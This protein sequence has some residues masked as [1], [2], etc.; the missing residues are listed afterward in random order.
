MRKLIFLAA[1]PFLFAGCGGG[2]SGENA[3]ELTGTEYAYVMPETIEGG[4]TTLDFENTGDEFHEFALAKIGGGKTFDDVRR[5]L[6]DPK[7]Q[8]QPPPAWV[9]I[10][11]GIPTLDAG[12]SAALTQN[13]EPGSYVLLCFL[14]A[15]DGKSH[16]AHGMVRAFEVEGDAGT[17]APETDA[18]LRLGGGLEAPS[19]EAG[20]RTLELKNDGDESGSVFLTAF[21][22]GKTEKDLERWEKTGM[23]GPAPAHFLGG[24]IDVPPHSSVYYTVTLEQGREYTLFDDVHGIQKTF[25][26]R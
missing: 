10:R 9:Q 20:K 1:A 12:E 3:V 13:L 23:R 11:P 18:T 5:Y 19:L 26:P 17:S 6:A 21:E 22:T 24:A 7:S 4:W 16:I 25:T 2:G 8:Q 15:P 14:D